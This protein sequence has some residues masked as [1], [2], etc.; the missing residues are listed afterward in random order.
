MQ[1]ELLSDFCCSTPNYEALVLKSRKSLFCGCYRPPRGEV[2]VFFSFLDSLFEFVNHYKYHIILGGDFNIN[3]MADNPNKA[4]FESLLDI[5]NCQNV[6]TSP[7]RLATTTET[8]IDVFITNFDETRVNSSVINYCLSDH[9][10]IFI[11]VNVSSE[12][13]HH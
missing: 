4:T 2:S 10:P 13:I 9:L 1:C 7:T 12:I 5:H 8:L 11:S 3:L 6:I